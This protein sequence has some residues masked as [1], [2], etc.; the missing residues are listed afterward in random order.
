MPKLP[1]EQHKPVPDGTFVCD[2]TQGHYGY[3]CLDG[4]PDYSAQFQANLLFCN[5]PGVSHGT[6][7]CAQSVS[8]EHA[9][10]C[11]ADIA[12]GLPQHFGPTHGFGNGPGVMPTNPSPSFSLPLDGFT[13]FPTGFPSPTDFPTDSPSS[14][15][16]FPTDSPFPSEF[17]TSSPFPSE[18]P[19]GSPFPSEFPTDG[20][21]SPTEFPTDSPSADSP[22]P[23]SPVEESPSPSFPFDT[24]PSFMPSDSP[25]ESP[26]FPSDPSETP[27]P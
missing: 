20:P 15:S 1:G 4:F 24:M 19:T 7:C 23:S 26:S 13:G 5:V 16:E 3:Y 18:F 27:S 9:R 6:F 21:S 25:V 22:T 17:P 10:T 2:Q 8:C 14:P 11:A 12:S